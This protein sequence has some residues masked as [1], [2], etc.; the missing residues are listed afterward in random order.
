MKLEFQ[1]ELERM[2]HPE[3]SRIPKYISDAVFGK[4]FD[5]N[6][7][8]LMTDPSPLSSANFKAIPAREKIKVWLC[9][10]YSNQVRLVNNLFLVA[11]T[12]AMDIE[13][14]F[15]CAAITG[16]MDLLQVCITGMRLE[17]IQ[18]QIM[19]NE[20]ALFRYAALGNHLNIIEKFLIVP[21][22]NISEMVKSADYAVFQ[23]AAIREYWP[24]VEKLMTLPEI[25]VE[26]MLNSRNYE[27][28]GDAA[29]QGK[30][31]VIEVILKLYKKH[32]FEQYEEKGGVVFKEALRQIFKRRDTLLRAAHCGQWDVIK[33]FILYPDV[34]MRNI[35]MDEV[36]SNC[37]SFLR[38]FHAAAFSGQWNVMKALMS[39]LPEKALKMVQY[40]SYSP[41]RVAAGNRHWSVV[42][43]LIAIPD[44]DVEAMLSSKPGEILFPAAS[45]RDTEIVNYLLTFPCIFSHAASHRQEYGHFIK[46]FIDKKL[47][48]LKHR[49]T[50]GHRTIIITQQEAR[51]C[52][53][54]LHYFIRQAQTPETPEVLQSIDFL[55]SIPILRSILHRPF[56]ANEG[57]NGLLR[58]AIRLNK[59]EIVGRLMAISNVKTQAEKDGFYEEEARGVVN[60]RRLAQDQESSV[61]A[62]SPQEQVM[63]ERIEKKY[64][65][66]IEQQG[67]Q[68]AFLRVY[69]AISERYKANPA[70]FRRKNGQEIK[71]PLNWEE[72]EA[73]NV[74]EEEKQAACKV[75]YQH[76]T[77]TVFRYLSKPNPWMSPQALYVCVERGRVRTVRWSTF[78]DY[79]ELITLL[80]LAAS[81]AS[82]PGIEGYTLETRIE[83]W[84][85]ELA[86]IARAHNWD[87][88]RDIVNKEG[89]VVREEY[90][91]LEG[92]KPSCYSG[93]K[94][95]LFQALKGHPLFSKDIHELVRLVLQERTRSYMLDKFKEMPTARLEAILVEYMKMAHGE[96]G[97]LG[98]LTNEL[99]VTSETI[100]SWKIALCQQ[101][102]SSFGEACVKSV[103]EKESADFFK[104]TQGLNHFL[105]FVER[106]ALYPL[107]QKELNKREDSLEHQ[108]TSMSLETR[109]KVL[110][111]MD[112]QV[113]ETNL[114]KLIHLGLLGKLGEKMG[115]EQ[116][117]QL[118]Y[119]DESTAEF[120]A[121]LLADYPEEE[122]KSWLSALEITKKEA[123]TH[124][125][126]TYAFPISEAS[127]AEKLMI[128]LRQQAEKNES[129]RLALKDLMQNK[130][131]VEEI[132]KDPSI[133]FQCA[134]KQNPVEE[135]EVK[136]FSYEDLRNDPTGEWAREIDAA[137]QQPAERSQLVRS[138]FFLPVSPGIRR[139]EGSS[140]LN[141]NP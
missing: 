66:M 60:I 78:M 99:E 109:L 29:S 69:E 53:S 104:S 24:I 9:C 4:E 33:N 119:P 101:Y 5:S 48:T 25:D 40:D 64:Q 19:K 110:K 27:I 70:V 35:F 13:D 68:K 98:A 45:S 43:N 138:H 72:F 73:L 97:K 124:K 90:D 118:L 49:Q 121:S 114:I 8:R 95:R 16:R 116:F 12:I 105:S 63:L 74:S 125:I 58:L 108:M 132:L 100:D 15:F 42:K 140:R 123:L 86:F 56:I 59:Q 71:L 85:H 134:S 139:G 36:S 102:S 77:H 61:M 38:I 1:S 34:N 130:R 52:L 131:S 32:L 57:T 47:E 44:V 18:S 115:T 30:W 28:Y 3:A 136:I 76:P 10:A 26:E 106:C 84:I 91:D 2:R 83:A 80:W 62:L 7:L 128:F 122:V 23:H 11:N 82:E 112:E 137:E 93:V 127:P 81:D 113:E 39:L 6:Y 37:G 126:K 79:E 133:A 65:S 107:C 21:G 41:I 89:K 17:R 92:D 46:P 50:V 120:Y 141:P 67:P 96:S 117:T 75:Y 111:E 135:T 88:S 31:K 87:K 94:R 51:L 54:I 20:Y 129:A 22:I 103:I 14:L 55:L